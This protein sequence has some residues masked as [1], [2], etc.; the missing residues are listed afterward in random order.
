MVIPV[1]HLNDMPDDEYDEEVDYLFNQLS[2]GFDVLGQ[3]PVP[4]VHRYANE[5]P[6]KAKKVSAKNPLQQ[7]PNS[8]TDMKFT[9]SL[10][11]HLDLLYSKMLAKEVSQLSSNAGVVEEELIDIA[12]LPHRKRHS[13]YNPGNSAVTES[14]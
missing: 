7:L 9:H 3:V 6:K 11:K 13:Y 5:K 2:S 14:M 4:K 1:K 10:I 8:V 12:G